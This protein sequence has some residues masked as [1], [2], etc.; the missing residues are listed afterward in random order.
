M[1]SIEQNPKITLESLRQQAKSMN[2]VGYSKLKKDELAAMIANTLTQA[3]APVSAPVQPSAGIQVTKKRVVRK[4]QEP[5]AVQPVQE[6]VLPAEK[7]KRTRKAKTI[8]ADN[9]LC[10]EPSPSQPVSQPAAP[11]NKA[12]SKWLQALGA[13]N[14]TR[15]VYSIPKKGSSEYAEVV[16]LMEQL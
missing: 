16:R 10:N 15:D 13:Y 2:L 3:Q 7:P 14:Q 9:C 12:K 8:K 4:Y 5:V 11:V 6:S 1:S